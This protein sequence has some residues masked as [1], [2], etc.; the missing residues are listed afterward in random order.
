MVV[1]APEQV[2]RRAEGHVLRQLA[3]AA[4]V[5]PALGIAQLADAPAADTRQ[6]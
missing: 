2:V 1:P 3:G 4:V 5:Q 6:R